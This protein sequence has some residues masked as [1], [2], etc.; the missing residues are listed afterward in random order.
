M[1]LAS[2]CSS[3]SEYLKH[4][5]NGRKSGIGRHILYGWCFNHLN[6]RSS[7]KFHFDRVIPASLT[8]VFLR[9]TP[10]SSWYVNP[11][12]SLQKLKCV[13]YRAILFIKYSIFLENPIVFLEIL[14]FSCLNVRFC[15][16]GRL[17][18]ISVSSISFPNTVLLAIFCNFLPF[19]SLTTSYSRFDQKHKR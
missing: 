15:L 9:L 10:I 14:L 13:Q 12:C 1:A 6:V 8:G 3:H 16:S 4:S 17:V 18:E 2:I 11:P 5:Q 7:F 19:F